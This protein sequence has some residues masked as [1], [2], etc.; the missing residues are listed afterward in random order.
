MDKDTAVTDKDSGHPLQVGILGRSWWHFQQREAWI[1][2]DDD[3]F[4]MWPLEDYLATECEEGD[5]VSMNGSIEAR[6]FITL[7]DGSRFNGAASVLSDSRAYSITIFR[8]FWG[9]VGLPLQDS[10]RTAEELNNLCSF[11]GKRPFGMR[12]RPRTEEEVFPMRVSVKVECI[13][14]DFEQNVHFPYM[15]GG[16]DVNHNTEGSHRFRLFQ[17][18]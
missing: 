7:H 1:M 2:V 17:T 13:G 4:T 3:K 8:G 16:W 5:I 9:R 15:E 10:N 14:L 18:R 12:Y 11:C 6:A